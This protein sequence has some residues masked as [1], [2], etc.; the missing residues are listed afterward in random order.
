LPKRDDKIEL[1][2]FN[3]AFYRRAIESYEKNK[4]SIE[5]DGIYINDELS[6]H[7]MFKM[8]Y[9]WM[10]GDNRH[11]SLDCRMWGYV[12]EDH[13]VG[14]AAIIWFSKDNEVDYERIRWE[15]IFQL[16]H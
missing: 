8:N 16:A 7:Y 14:K 1:T 3:I 12:P 5:E 11:N 10:M 13:V 2:E 4:V 6:T 9:Y 15:R